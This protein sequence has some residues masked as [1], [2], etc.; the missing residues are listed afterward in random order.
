M[1]G[2]REEF[3]FNKNNVIC[4]AW[5]VNETCVLLLDLQELCDFEKPLNLPALDFL[6]G[7]GQIPVPTFLGFLALIFI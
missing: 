1:N 3:V 2:W 6:I 4:K 5:L 7:K